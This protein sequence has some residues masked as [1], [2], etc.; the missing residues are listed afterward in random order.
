MAFGG[1]YFFRPLFAFFNRQ[2]CVKNVV[3]KLVIEYVSKCVVV[4][5]L[6]EHDFS[7]FL[8]ILGHR[9]LDGGNSRVELGGKR[10][11]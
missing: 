2:L 5:D 6:I 3:P 11:V 8:A 1:P 7:L 10:R 4:W 9:M